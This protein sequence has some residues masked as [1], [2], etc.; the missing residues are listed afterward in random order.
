M[1]ELY[2]G[3]SLLSCVDLIVLMVFAGTNSRI[4][5][6]K[7]NSFLLAYSILMLNHCRCPVDC[8]KWCSA[9]DNGS[10]YCDEVLR[11]YNNTCGFT[12]FHASIFD[13]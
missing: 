4:P 8:V 9:M 7:R 2:L 10:A 6:E 12:V 11:L 3:I 13:N 1:R 5:A